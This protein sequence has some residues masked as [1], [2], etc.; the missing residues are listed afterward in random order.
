MQFGQG[1]QVPAYIAL[2]RV[3]VCVPC[4][5]GSGLVLL[6]LLCCRGADGAPGGDFFLFDYGV[7]ACW[8]ERGKGAGRR[9][10]HVKRNLINHGV[11]DYW[12][13]GHE[14]V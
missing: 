7:V 1:G 5:L 2:N 3:P 13:K 6:M 11:I 4:S 10:V 8:G 14:A 12:E 9:G